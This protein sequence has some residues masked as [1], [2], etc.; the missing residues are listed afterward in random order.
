LVSHKQTGVGIY[1]GITT[2]VAVVN[3]EFAIVILSDAAN[4]FGVNTPFSS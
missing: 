1:K 4:G 2:S 3:D